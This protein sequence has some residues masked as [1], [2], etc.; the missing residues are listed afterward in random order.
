MCQPKRVMMAEA[1]V[2]AVEA[3]VVEAMVVEVEKNKKT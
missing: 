1:E 2:Q 3:M